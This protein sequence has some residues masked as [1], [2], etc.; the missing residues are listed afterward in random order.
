MRARVVAITAGLLALVL[1]LGSVVVAVAAVTSQRRTVDADLRRVATQVA[2]L[3]A[4]N[5]VPS[6]LPVSGA[7]IVQ[8]VGPD[9][10]IVAASP[11]ADRLVPLLAEEELAAALAGEAV[12]VPAGRMA[13]GGTLRVVAVPAGPASRGVAVLAASPVDDLKHTQ[14]GLWL[15]L[16]A[17]VPLVVVVAAVLAWRA[18]GASLRAVDALRA[19]AE[20]IGAAGDLGERLPEPEAHDEIRSLAITL[21]GMLDRLEESTTAQRQFVADAAHELRSPVASLR[22][23]IEVAARLGQDDALAAEV[24]PEVDRL[25]R[26]IDDLLLL[27]R[28]AA[29]Q[30]PHRRE[31][32][33]LEVLVAQIVDRYT[34]ARVP[35]RLNVADAVTVCIDPTAIER[36]VANLVDNAVRHASSVVHVSVAGS[37]TTAVIEV[38]D[39]GAGIAPADRERVFD[40]FVRLDEARDR[41][42]GGSGIGLPI[43]RELVRREGGEVRLSDAAP[44]VCAQITFPRSEN[45]LEFGPS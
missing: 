30:T 38:A 14:W 26:L 13:E 27:A 1:L 34:Q 39:D 36:A 10:S 6:T 16:A 4:E 35:V 17:G 7:R 42:A 2:T 3:V 25:A 12:Q 45:S 19:G 28:T 44:G 32:V 20:Q 41:D 8:V 18:V 37:A 24:L 5:R 43:T 33:E 31:V 21:N 29:S 15:A 23:Q 11:A 22:M 40:R 9:F